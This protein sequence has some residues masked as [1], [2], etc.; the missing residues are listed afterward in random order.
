MGVEMNLKAFAKSF[1]IQCANPDGVYVDFT[2]GNGHDTAFLCEL[3]K[4]GIVYAF[5]VQVE[6]LENTQAL[7]DEK[8]LCNA[9]LIL[10]GH[11]NVKKYVNCPID[12]GMFNLGYR[13]GGDKSKHTMR[14]TT[15]KA[16]ADGIDLLKNGCVMTVSVY[17]GHAE[18]FAEGEA[19]GE[20][21]SKYDKKELCVMCHRMVNSPT[22]PYIYQILKY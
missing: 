20:M 2:M 9:K 1:L 12:G 8:G 14:N 7:L 10:S 19:L 4:N 3:A 15:L 11:E 6:A 21:L 13:P 16:V 17:P 22:S 18:G 5:D